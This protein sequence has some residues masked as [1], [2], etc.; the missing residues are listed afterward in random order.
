MVLEYANIF[1][2][3]TICK[4]KIWWK[5]WGLLGIQMKTEQVAISELF[6][7]HSMISTSKLHLYSTSK[8]CTNYLQAF[9]SKIAHVN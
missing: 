3:F 6:S 2:K 9:M 4:I 1:Q 8:S 5:L 7:L